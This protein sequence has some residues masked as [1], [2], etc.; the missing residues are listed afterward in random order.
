MENIIQI[1]IAQ[2]DSSTIMSNGDFTNE[3][4]VPVILEEGDQIVLN[5]TFIDT[6]SEES[7]LVDIDRDIT[8]CLE[9]VPYVVADD[10]TKFDALNGMGNN[11]APSDC[12]NYYPYTVTSSGGGNPGNY[13]NMYHVTELTFMAD[14]TLEQSTMGSGTAAGSDHPLPILYYDYNKKLQHTTIICPERNNDLMDFWKNEVKVTVDLL[15]YDMSKEADAPSWTKS[16]NYRNGIGIPNYN[17]GTPDGKVK[18]KVT[19]DIYEKN[20]GIFYQMM[21]SDMAAQHRDDKP[22]S[23]ESKDSQGGI[24]VEVSTKKT[25]PA[26]E[27]SANLK[28]FPF[29]C[30]I[31]A[32]KYTPSQLTTLLNNNFANNFTPHTYTFKNL[33]N[34][35]FLKY[36][37]PD[38][39]TDPAGFSGMMFSGTGTRVND[40]DGNPKN[41]ILVSNLGVDPVDA[42]PDSVANRSTGN[43]IGSNPP[44]LSTLKN[45]YLLGS[46]SIEIEFDDKSSKFYWNQLHTPIYDARIIGGVGGTG[47]VSTQIV[48]TVNVDGNPNH[49]IRAK[50]SGVYFASMSAYETTPDPS[51]VPQNPD[52]QVPY[53]FWSD[54]LG[55]RYGQMSPALQSY[56]Q[57]PFLGG[58]GT[59]TLLNAIECI[60]GIHTTTAVHTIDG[61]TDK[62]TV[63][64]QQIP[65]EQAFNPDINLAYPYVESNSNQ[66]VFAKD[67]TVESQ[68]EDVT[69]SGYF[70]I[71]LIAGFQSTMIGSEKTDKNIHGIVNR[72]FNR[73]SYTSSTEQDSLVYTHKGAPLILSSI[74][75]RILLPD[76]TVPTNIG[77]D[78]TIF[79]QVLKA[80][81]PPPPPK[82]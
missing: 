79:L 47:A 61:I 45:N 4:S 82:K 65:I 38:S 35:S 1:E 74:R 16:M 29:K 31:P 26:T 49:H 12:Y 17:D 37:S 64:Y 51:A 70:L 18:S 22:F 67:I 30:E 7:G 11:P 21:T 3:L 15:V 39:A 75:S 73:G 36:S 28:S 78:N 27:A 6:E 14:N 23:N 32:A 56:K 33:L 81:Q 19:H 69:D 71:E 57:V 5:K 53:D 63:A 42:E 59:L 20:N 68:T 48:R 44:I 80:Q 55:F 50:S 62:K 2:R 40:A 8:V 24:F 43:S 10:S 58:G 25:V 77:S 66:V 13:E 72:Y 34:S 46:D 60:D 54:K 9:I 52:N 76:R 41:N